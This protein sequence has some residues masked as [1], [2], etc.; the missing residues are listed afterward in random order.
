MVRRWGLIGLVLVGTLVAVTVMARAFSSGATGFSGNPATGG[1]TC[2]QCH[3]GGVTPTVT[4]DGPATVLSGIPVTY[5]LVISGGQGVAGG[6]N[7]S[8]ISGT[9]AALPGA[10]DVLLIGGE[11]THAEPKGVDVD[12]QVT[13][14]FR[15]TPPPGG[16]V[17]AM[18]GAGNSVDLMNGNQ[19]DRASTAVRQID[20]V[21]LTETLYLPLV[22]RQP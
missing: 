19:G 8:V 2:N 5:T 3:S 18:Y 20:V 13:F 22:I 17:V 11:L 1:Q 21:V 4:I 9:L 7:V 16:G 15:W 10:T 6:F 14:T 12:G